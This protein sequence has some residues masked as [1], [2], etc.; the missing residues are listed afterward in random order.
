M[1]LSAT[2][3]ISFLS[4]SFNHSKMSDVQNSDVDVTPSPFILADQWVAVSKHS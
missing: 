2:S 1:A 4:R 3:I